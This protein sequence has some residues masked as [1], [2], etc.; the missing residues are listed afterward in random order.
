VTGADFRRLVKVRRQLKKDLEEVEEI[1]PR[2]AATISLAAERLRARIREIKEA[3]NSDFARVRELLPEPCVALLAEWRDL[4]IERDTL[5]YFTS[6]QDLD[7]RV[8]GISVRMEVI[9]SEVED[10]VMEAES[11]A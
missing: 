9:S 2:Y 8:F 6:A 11:V 4:R 1:Y 5:R 7:P 3:L 10:R